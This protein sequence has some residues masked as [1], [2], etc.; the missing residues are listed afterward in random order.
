M[1]RPPIFLLL[2]MT[3]LYPILYNEYALSAARSIASVNKMVY[4]Y[5]RKLRTARAE[6]E[7]QRKE[8]EE[9]DALRIELEE[10][11]AKVR[12]MRLEK[13][14]M[15]KEAKV[16]KSEVR[17][18]RKSRTDFVRGRR[19]TMSWLRSLLLVLRR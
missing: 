3:R 6:L 17:R 5:K 12:A 19:C 15:K 4:E 10:E 14:R 11:R 8:L 16:L 2:L 9:M 7:G 13:K 1:I 18:L